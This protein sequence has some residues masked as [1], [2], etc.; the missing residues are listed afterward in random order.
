M[1]LGHMPHDAQAEAR[2]ARASGTSLVDAEEAL[3]DAPLI[4]RGDADAL[5]R[6]GDLDGVVDESRADP[7]PRVRRRVL[8]RVGHEVREAHEEVSPLAVDERIH[9]VAEHDVDAAHLGGHAR[10]VD[11]EREDLVDRDELRVCEGVAR[12]QPGQ[13]DELVGDRGQAQALLAEPPREVLDLLHVTRRLRD[14]LREQRDRADGGLELVTH[15][16]HEV[17]AHALDAKR[18]RAIL[19]QHQEEPRR[20][21]RRTHPDMDFRA[22]EGT[23]GDLE[24]LSDRLALTPRLIHNGPDA[25]VEA[26]AGTDEPL[27]RG[28]RGGLVDVPGRV[29]DDHD[30][31]EGAEQMLDALGEAGGECSSCLCLPYRGDVEQPDKTCTQEEA[32]YDRKDHCDGRVH[33]PSIWASGLDTRRTRVGYLGSV[34]SPVRAESLPEGLGDRS[35]Q[36]CGQRHIARCHE[37]RG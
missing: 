33:V 8:D 32:E 29:G 22:P 19:R 30:R 3:E 11:G 25:L 2:P 28:S 4:L 34:E 21:G 37:T 16:G 24:V 36:K 31:V 15:I 23:S 6:D 27:R 18:L 17:S 12:L 10:L 14:G 1:V 35:A 9:V 7:H 20:E 26:P 5:V 13:L